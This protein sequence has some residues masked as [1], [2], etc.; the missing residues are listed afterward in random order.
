LRLLKLERILSADAELQPLLAKA[1]DLRVL[2]ALVQRFLAAELAPQARVANFKDG[3]LALLAAHPAA[4]AKLKL[5]APALARFLQDRRFQVN[6]VSVRVQ[7]RRRAAEP[8][9]QPKGVQFSTHALQRLRALHDRLPPSPARE[10]LA[11]MLRRHGAL[12]E[13]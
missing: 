2:G 6:S 12:G 9:R 7:P 8:S 1:E 3:E 11:A 5:L 13:G 10:R 4:A